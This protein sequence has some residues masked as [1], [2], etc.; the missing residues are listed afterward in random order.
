V[1]RGLKQIEAAIQPDGGIY[2]PESTHQNY[3]TAIALLA[4]TSANADGRYNAPISKAV[5]Y[6]KDIQWDVK[7]AGDRSNLAFGGGGY[8]SHSRPDLSNT[9][10]LLDALKAAGVSSHDEAMQNAM[11]FVSRCQNLSSP[12]NTTPFAGKIQDGGFYYT[13]AAGGSSPA[14]TTPEG[15]LR[16]Y[17]SMTYAGLRSMIYAGVTADDP[18]V[19]AAQNW[20]RRFYSLNEN[21]GIGQSG[22]YY[23]YQTFAK[24]LDALGENQFVDAQNVKHDWRAELAEK[25]ISQQKENGSWSNE[26]T[27]WYEGD[28]NLVTG[29][30]LM[31]LA[32]CQS[33][34][35]DT[36]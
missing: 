33:R 31:S 35:S 26:T 17:G 1:Q 24:T 27:R 5:A 29:Y 22:L 20:I 34:P 28:P 16:S 36:K 30:A 4:L 9:V 23:Y 15:G 7:E 12:D 2:L 6:L 21:P 3:E 13:P 10:F 19:Q 18:R 32:R 8:G 14:G 11:V 25:L